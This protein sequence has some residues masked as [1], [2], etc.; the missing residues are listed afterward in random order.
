MHVL[1]LAFK[2]RLS[3]REAAELI[4]DGATAGR[5]HVLSLLQ[6]GVALNELVPVLLVRHD[7][8]D[9]NCAALVPDPEGLIDADQTLVERDA[10][11]AWLDARNFPRPASLLP[12]GSPQCQQQA[13]PGT[14]G[15]TG[16]TA[17]Q[18]RADA[19][20]R[21]SDLPASGAVAPGRVAWIKILQENI[22]AID[23]EFGGKASVLEV[24]RWLKDHGGERILADGGREAI[25]WLDDLRDRQIVQ[26]KR[27]SN[28]ISDARRLARLPG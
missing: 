20:E 1:A 10:L 23:A 24:I 2:R 9:W 7:R 27:I 17:E 25:V 13:R 18:R 6:E 15:A 3:L 28:A 16:E 21:P 22:R 12:E 26:K 5:K 4:L 19:A 8:Y 11:L 14:K